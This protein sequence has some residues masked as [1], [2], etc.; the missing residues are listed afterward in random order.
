MVRANFSLSID[1]NKVE[2][3]NCPPGKTYPLGVGGTIT[4]R[5]NESFDRDR[6]P[7]QLRGVRDFSFSLIGVWWVYGF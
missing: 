5:R 7:L 4:A 2:D 1:A 3:S 6:I